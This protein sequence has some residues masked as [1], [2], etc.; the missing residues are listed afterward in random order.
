M[1]SAKK[2]L[3]GIVGNIAAAIVMLI[4]SILAF[5]VVIFIVRS[6]ASIAGYQP[7]G[8]YVVLSSAV[9]TGFSILA[10][11]WKEE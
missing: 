4:I 2:I 3:S 10:G 5:F 7:A 1:A 11:M 6:G 9:L 8:D